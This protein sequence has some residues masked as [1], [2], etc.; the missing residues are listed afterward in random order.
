MDEGQ[1]YPIASCKVHLAVKKRC[2]G[3][4]EEQGGMMSDQWTWDAEPDFIFSTAYFE[5]AGYKGTLH[6]EGIIDI[7]VPC[8]EGVIVLLSMTIEQF[9][10]IAEQ[11]RL[12]CDKRKAK[13]QNR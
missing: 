8:G 4:A 1:A 2:G 5:Y 3:L 12:F 7:E 6:A 9:D 10:K 13:E 11:A